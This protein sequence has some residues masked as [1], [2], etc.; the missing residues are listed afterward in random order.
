VTIT[1][2]RIQSYKC[3]ADV[4]VMQG[5]ATDAAE[6]AADLLLLETASQTDVT[7]RGATLRCD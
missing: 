4:C 1:A 6:A 3:V 5:D 7:D 2:G